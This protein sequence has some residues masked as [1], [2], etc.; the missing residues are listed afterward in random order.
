MERYFRKVTKADCKLLFDWANDPETRNNSFNTEPIEWEKHVE[1]FDGKLKDENCQMYIYMD[2][3]MPLGLVRIDGSENEGTISYSIAPDKRG[4]GLGTSMLLLLEKM[5]SKKMPSDFLLK[6]EVKAENKGSRRIFEKLGYIENSQ[7]SFQKRLG[8]PSTIIEKKQRD[9]GLE[10]L[11]VLAMMMVVVLHYL[12]KG[13][14]LKD[15]TLDMS[16]N[17][18]LFWLLECFA[19]SCVNVYVLISGY[20]LVDSRF[21]LSR[22]IRI[23]GQVFFYSVGI[24]VIMVICGLT[25]LSEITNLY[26]LYFLIC[27]VTGFHYWFAS[28][29]VFMLLFAPILALGV[30]NLN[31]K[32]L[33]LVIVLL[34]SVF[35]LLKTFV[36][37]KLQFDDSGYSVL[38]FVILFIVASYI[39]LYGDKLIKTTIGGMGIYITGSICVWLYIFA[40]AIFVISTK[41]FN[42]L[43]LQATD[44]NFI[45]V[46][47]ASVGLFYAFKNLQIKENAFTAFIKRIAPYT[48]GVYLIHEHILVAHKWED[49]LKV[50]N[51]YGVYRVL[52]IILTVILIFTLGVLVDMVRALIF[53]GISKLANLCL[54][55]YYAK[56]E[57]WDYLIFGF[58]TT[59]VNWIAYALASRLYLPFFI[60]DNVFLVQSVSNVI[61]WIMAVA[62]AYW[63]NRCFVFKSEATGFI[64]VLREI[65]SFVGARLFSFGVEQVLFML[66]ISLMGINDLLVKFLVGFVVIALNYIFS[67]LFIFK[68]KMAK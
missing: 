30:K 45:F 39:K 10:L 54:L 42:N 50:G 17:N 25:K 47:I 48:F 66:M 43:V 28:G 61:S 49:W 7:G 18:M 24:A 23:W 8:T 6:A 27:P 37:F 5:L 53:K 62:F 2:F 12:Q 46:L 11:R 41:K 56:K 58:L 33:E 32:T 52:H 20:Y 57:V 38:W 16:A 19:I 9:T 34:L 59:V 21:S 3:F 60:K 51:T 40:T 14:L 1:W 4:Q 35:C 63:T 29:Y 22:I 65:A 44:Y 55:I 13:G 26:D 64:P 36:P 67:K 31:K 15:A 68:T